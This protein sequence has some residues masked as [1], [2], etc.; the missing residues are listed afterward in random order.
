MKKI[1]VI[2]LL[3]SALAA[4]AV[5]LY[6]QPPHTPGATGGNGLSAFFGNLGDPSV[7]YDRQIADDF[8]VPA[9]G[10][11][12]EK[13][14]TS[15]VQFTAGDPNPITAMNYA[16]Y[17]NTGTGVGSLVTSGS[18]ASFTR[19]TGPNSYFGR[20]EQ[21]LAM[22]VNIALGPGSYFIMVQP[23]VNHNWFWITSS[24]TTTFG[25]SAHL[26]RGP[27]AV[28]SDPTW[29]TNWTST[30]N[31]IF[32]ARYDQSMKLEGQVIPEPATLAVVGFGLAALAA[33]RRRK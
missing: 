25:L 5:V 12:I 1:A 7:V 6:E 20:P 18:A 8:N 9:P 17:N 22:D 26:R 13:I 31:A 21:L 33:R 28:N 14:T 19:S 29:P 15:W 3:A 4:N 10:W 32:L 11:I 23:T 24:P 30:E 2:G 16:V 27:G